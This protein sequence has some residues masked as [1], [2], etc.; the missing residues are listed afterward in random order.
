MRAWLPAEKGAVV[1]QAPKAAIKAQYTPENDDTTVADPANDVTAVTSANQDRFAKRRADALTTM[2]QTAL[3]HGPEPQPGAT[4]IGRLWLTN[5]NG[6]GP[7]N[8][9]H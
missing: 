7:R 4:T 5:G 8:V 2:A 6:A 9:H 3:R 1:L